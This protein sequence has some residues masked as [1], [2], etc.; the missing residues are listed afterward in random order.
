MSQSD[1]VHVDVAIVGGGM[2]GAV[3]A[4]SLAALKGKDGAPLQILLLEASAPEL[5][6]HPGFDARAIALS[7]GTCEA[8]ARHG[9]WPHLAPHCSPI[10]HIHVSD[11]G[12][13]GQTRLSAAEYGLPALGQVIELSAAG[14]VLQ[15]AIAACPQIRMLCP[16][17]LEAIDPDEGGVTLALEGGARYR[18]RLLVAADGGHSFV[19]QHFKMPVSRHDYGQSAIIATVKTA[20]DPAGRAF[21]RFT[22][23]GPLAL[24][25]MQDGLSSLVWSVPRDEAQALMALDDAAFLARLQQAFG[26]RLGRFVRTGARNLYPLVLTVADY[27]L[28]QRTV[29]VGNAAHLLHPI[30]GQGFNL[31]MRDLD[32]LTRTLARALE[33]GEDI[34]GFEVLSGYWQQR[35]DDQAQT[36]WL[37]SSLAQL[38]S[39]HHAP[40]VVGR[41]LAL[42]LMGRVPWL[43]APLASRTLG[44]VGEVCGQ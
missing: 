21:E 26:W 41:N 10:T 11:R 44:F 6:A 2:S 25:P 24:L 43:K 7:A 27:P 16:A 8:L 30:A 4:L 3:L 29:L 42:S 5:N 23:G 12:H 14:I 17:R 1:L 28:A 37:T 22:D 18:T 32:V 33:A 20:E 15:E 31:G 38:F 9:L 35:R 36:V 40:L 34:G 13:C 19:R 39:N